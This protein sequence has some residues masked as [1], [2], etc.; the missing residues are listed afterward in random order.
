MLRYDPVLASG[1]TD[2]AF[3]LGATA[4]NIQLGGSVDV[5]GH[6][7]QRFN[8]L[9]RGAIPH[10]ELVQS[11]Q[12]L[13]T[14][15]P[16][17]EDLVV[18]SILRTE[19][20]IWG[21]LASHDSLPDEQRQR[22]SELVAG[23]GEV[24]VFNVFEAHRWIR[25]PFIEGVLQPGE[26]LRSDVKVTPLVKFPKLA[27][28]LQRPVFI[29]FEGRQRAGSLKVRGSVYVLIAARLLGRNPERTP[30]VTASLGNYAGGLV[31]AARFL[32]YRNVEVVLP[33]TVSQE[34]ALQ[35][36]SL[37]AKVSRV[38]ETLEQADEITRYL[39]EDKPEALYLSCLD[40][41]MFSM[42]L[43]TV[44]VEI[45]VQMN[46]NYNF[47]DY[48]VIAPAGTGMFLMGLGTYLNTRDIA[49]FG[50]QSQAFSN[51]TRSFAQKSIVTTAP[52][53]PD[54]ESLAES[55]AVQAVVPRNFHAILRLV[56]GMK[57]VSE[58]A[59]AEAMTYMDEA[60]FMSEG[61]AT[62][63]VAALLSGA[64]IDALPSRKPVVLVHTGANIAQAILDEIARRTRESVQHMKAV[65][66]KE[67]TTRPAP[68]P[69]FDSQGT[70]S[71]TDL[72]E[73]KETQRPTKD[74]GDPLKKT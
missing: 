21:A 50:V 35:L 65:D 69:H 22:L 39:M 46:R 53:M 5:L 11:V 66:P 59:I 19:G 9:Q 31:M 14:Q 62:L 43:G 67:R 7:S 58:T 17:S 42:G 63:P 20:R 34:K 3:R 1:L 18:D 37:G 32:N 25:R 70:P 64:F 33:T 54:L 41:P 68:A 28:H 52:R 38:G 29:K 10:Q 15:E 55:V 51:L 57:A 23:R 61:A 44:G 2:L 56:T 13:Q 27:E 16:I 72:P 26:E 74:P 4:T 12:A 45:D 6:F 48:D 49:L 71:F 8:L 60:G 40:H 73:P 30:V 36:Q 24:S 47:H